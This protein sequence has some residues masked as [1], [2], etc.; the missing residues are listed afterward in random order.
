MPDT[1]EDNVV[2][3]IRYRILSAEGEDIDESTA[4]EPLTYLHGHGNLVP[5]LERALTG[6]RVGDHVAVTLAPEDAFGA[7][8]ADAERVLPLDAFPEGVEIEPGLPF[9]LEID[10]ERVSLFVERVDEASVVASVNHPLSG[11]T[12][13]FLADVE[14]LRAATAEEIEHGHALDAAADDAD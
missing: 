1:I 7:L 11:Q 8:V 12:L 14:T 2:V 5:G 3:T 6:K 10:E 4:D 9:D 13:R